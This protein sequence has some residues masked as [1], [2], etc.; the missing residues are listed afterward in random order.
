MRRIHAS[1]AS[2]V[3]G[4]KGV[5]VGAVDNAQQEP[6]NGD[7]LSVDARLCVAVGPHRSGPK[8]TAGV[9]LWRGLFLNPLER[10]LVSPSGA[11]TGGVA[12][13]RPAFG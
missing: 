4:M 12:H 10:G 5:E 8:P 3:A 13:R 2:I 11:K 7:N 1:N 6:G 9:W